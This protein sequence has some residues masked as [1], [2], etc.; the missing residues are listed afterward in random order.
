MHPRM[1]RVARPWDRHR[2][3]LDD[4]GA[5]AARQ[6]VDLVGEAERLFQI[7]GDKQNADPLALDQSDYVLDDAGA[8]DGVERGEGLVHQDEARLH[9]QD[10]GESDALARPAAEAARV[11]VTKAGEP[12][13]LQPG[14]G[15]GE[16]PAALDTSKAKAQ[17]NIVARR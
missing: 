12:E 9:G 16:S 5:R 11:A 1:D 3:M 15:L 2:V 14:F 6:Q 7:V 17:R 13:P 4:A 10:L 8:H